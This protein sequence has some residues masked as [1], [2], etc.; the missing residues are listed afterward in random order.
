MVNLLKAVQVGIRL[1]L[2]KLCFRVFN[3]VT[4]GIR[5]DTK[6][7]SCNGQNYLSIMGKI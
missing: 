1:Q 7:M 3:L 5:E 2:N 4:D 6:R